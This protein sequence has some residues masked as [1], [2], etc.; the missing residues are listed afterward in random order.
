LKNW[1]IIELIILLSSIKLCPFQYG[2]RKHCSS[3]H[4][5]LDIVGKIQKYMN[6]KLFSCGIFIDLRK[7]VDTVD[8]NIL[9]YK[10]HRYGIRSVI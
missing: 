1:Y 8:H 9:L 10:L 5:L 7:A 3:E 4:A 6:E 2:F